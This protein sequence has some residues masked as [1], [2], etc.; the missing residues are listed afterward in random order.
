MPELPEVETI[1]NQLSNEI[2]ISRPFSIDELKY[3]IVIDSIL[4]QKDFEPIG[5]KIHQIT[6]FGKMLVFDCE[7]HLML[8]QLGMSGS[9][10]LQNK[11]QELKKHTH[12]IFNDHSKNYFLTYVDPRRFGNLYYYTQIN[13]EKKLESSGV[14]LTSENLNPEVIYEMLKKYPERMLKVTLLDQSLFAGMGNYLASEV[15]A[16][17]KLRPTK[18]C[19]KISKKNSIDIYNA[20]KNVVSGAIKSNGTTFSG[21]YQDAY[22]EKGDGVNNLVVFYQKIC[23]LCGVTEVKKIYLAKRGTYYCPKCQ[24]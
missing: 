2:S 20:I 12:V 18:K 4:K 9:W 24:K 3:S 22:G 13:L 17:A 19:K 5:K 7:S 1:K 16:H 10:I 8:S 23:Q 15:C 21:G 14:D 11:D 6:R